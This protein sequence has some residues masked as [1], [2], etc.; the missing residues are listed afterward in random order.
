MEKK[1]VITVREADGGIIN[2]EIH[3]ALASTAALAREYALR[4]YPDRYIVFSENILPESTGAKHKAQELRRGVHF[5]CILRPSIFPSQAALLGHLSVTAFVQ[6]LDEHTTHHLGIGWVSDVFCDGE[7][8]GG[9]TIEGKLDSYTTYEYII[10]TFDAKIDENAFPPR[11]G[12][13]VRK[14]FESENT[15]IP[16]IIARNVLAKFFKLYSTL[17]SSSRFMDV[18]SKRFILRGKSARY[19]ENGKRKRCK[20]LGVEAKT[21]NLIIETFGRG[22]RTEKLSSSSS[23]L[24]PKKIRLKKKEITK[25]A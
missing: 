9:V 12:D 6:A 7:R 4:G 10:V 8:I 20:I 18:Y 19:I 24:L 25:L 11:L 21:G 17:K 2:M 1:N 14:V 15:S 16:M 5:S 3:E 13:M 22:A 23:V